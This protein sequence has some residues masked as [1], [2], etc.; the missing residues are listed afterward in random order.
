MKP[1]FRYTSESEIPAALKEFYVKQ[2]DGSYTIDIDG[3]AEGAKL[4]EFRDNN[5]VLLKENADLKKAW[6]GLN[7]DE[8]RA[9]MAKKD[10]IENAKIK[11]KGEFEKQMAER[12]TQVK[13]A[14]EAEKEKL[15]K[16]LGEKQSTIARLKIDAKLIEQGAQLGIR[17]TAH[18]DLLLRGQRVFSLDENDNIVASKDGK[19]WYDA[20]GE[21]LTIEKWIGDILKKDADHLFAPNQGGGG[22]GGKQPHT[23]GYTGK[24]PFDPKAPNITEQ[25]RL[26]KADRPLA[27]RLAQEAGVQVPGLTS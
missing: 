18:Q 12:L 25:G 1:K 3:A 26:M 6:E 4:A 21:L 10:D 17:D 8:V 24:N 9:L 16:T 2:A 7:A 27:T 5:R 15:T 22:G 11:D 23:G 20:G 13:A 19:P 14:H